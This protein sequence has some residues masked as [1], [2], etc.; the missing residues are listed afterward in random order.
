MTI[1]IS[2]IK[3]ISYMPFGNCRNSQGNSGTDRL[4]T[5]QR[6]DSTGLYYYSARYY[7]PT[8]GRFI[9]PDRSAPHV[10]NPQSLNKYSYVINNPTSAVDPSG[11]DYIFV[12]GANSK[13][14]D[15]W[16]TALNW[17]GQ[18]RVT[19]ISDPLSPG[20]PYES[21]DQASQLMWDLATGDYHDIK[22]IGH[23]EGALA[24]VSVLDAMA[25]IP[26]LL[27][28]ARNEIKAAVMLDAPT[29]IAG[30]F[31]SGFDQSD[32]NNL[33]GRLNKADM[34]T[35]LLDVWNEASPVHSPG[36]MPGW[37][38]SNTYSYDSRSAAYRMY[39]EFI[40]AF[41]Y[42]DVYFWDMVANG[43]DY[44]NDPTTNPGV[45][46]RIGDFLDDL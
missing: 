27:P 17:D 40:Y 9:S 23:S 44:H 3:S 6:L 43:V 16:W 37:D 8:I 25:D 7:D 38:D 12:G 20:P 21:S 18:E 15:T 5:G 41:G 29:G 26:T 36:P 1:G 46:D 10:S 19:F 14:S 31:V 22:L 35:G 32:Y 11:L 34:K 2:R 24:I 4:F 45:M 42:D 33:P 13:W 30:S 28:N 39:L